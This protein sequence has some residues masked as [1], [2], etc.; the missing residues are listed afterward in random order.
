V[1]RPLVCAA[2]P[3]STGRQRAQCPQHDDD[4]RD[5]R[6]TSTDRIEAALNQLINSESP[7]ARAERLRREL[8]M[9]EHQPSNDELEAETNPVKDE[10]VEADE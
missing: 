3:V 1:L 6:Q 7:A 10:V 8:R 4:R 5:A 2:W 9:I